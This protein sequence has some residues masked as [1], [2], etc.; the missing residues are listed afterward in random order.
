MLKRKDHLM[1][2]GRVSCIA[3]MAMMS[4]GISQAQIVGNANGYVFLNNANA[5]AASLSIVPTLATADATFTTTALSY[6]PG[7]IGEDPFNTGAIP[8]TPPTTFNTF[9][10]VGTLSTF[11]GTPSAAFH[12]NDSV[13]GTGNGTL[14]SGNIDPNNASNGGAQNP[15]GP[16]TLFYF[17]GTMHLNAGVNT[18]SLSH[19]DGYDLLVGGQGGDP[20]VVTDGATFIGDN[21]LFPF[22]SYTTSGTGAG[23]IND[24]GSAGHTDFFSLD[25][26]VSGNYSFKL[27]YGECCGPPAELT[28][29]VNQVPDAATTIGLLGVSLSVLAAFARRIKQ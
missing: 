24:G 29:D 26:S 15:S 8:G 19:D 22:G 1:P 12:A 14:G 21:G 5:N 10:Q 7:Q 20:G 23:A 18:F 13:A 17:T 6:N 16:G 25:A 9:L 11:T 28:M 3:A 4:A 2:L 27:S